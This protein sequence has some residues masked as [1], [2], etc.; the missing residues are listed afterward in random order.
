MCADTLFYN[1]TVRFCAFSPA[2]RHSK[3]FS[4]A[5]DQERKISGYNQCLSAWTEERDVALIHVKG[6]PR[7]GEEGMFP[8]GF[9]LAVGGNVAEDPEQEVPLQD[10]VKGGGD[11]DVA[12]LLQ[13]HALEHAAGVDVG[14]ARHL[15]LGRVHP[16]RPVELHLRTHTQG[17]THTH[18]HTETHTRTHT[19][20]QTHTHKHKMKY[21]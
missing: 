9:L 14:A 17:E 7:R 15:L 13:V 10:G 6:G 2:T 12:A 21:V 18:T 5:I 8:P 20:M 11:D 19:Q 1:L 16:V 4:T 3:T